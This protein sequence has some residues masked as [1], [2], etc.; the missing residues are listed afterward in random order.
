MT[1]RV[2][3]V[4][5]KNLFEAE[6]DGEHAGQIEYTR[7]DGAIVYTHTEVDGPF[8]GKGVGGALVRAA[9]DAARAEGVKVVPRC[10]FVRTWIERHPDYADLLG[11]A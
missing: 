5:E 9:L 11:G 8:E 10:S 7:R 6:V 1:V 2:T 4:P 3:A